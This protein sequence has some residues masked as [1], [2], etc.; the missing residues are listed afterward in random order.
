MELLIIQ[1]STSYSSLWKNI[2]LEPITIESK[3]EQETC[4]HGK[5]LW[6]CNTNDKWKK[7]KYWHFLPSERGAVLLNKYNE[8]LNYSMKYNL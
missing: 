8:I 7:C 6:D 5:N 4:Y 2:K 3:I 1:L